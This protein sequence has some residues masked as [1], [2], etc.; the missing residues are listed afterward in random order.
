MMARGRHEGGNWCSFSQRLIAHRE[1]W[2]FLM[3]IQIYFA[4]LPLLHRSRTFRRWGLC[5]DDVG[6]SVG[7]LVVSVGRL[8]VSVGWLVVPVGWLVGT[9]AGRYPPHDDIYWNDKGF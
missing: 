3:C 8:V 7:W 9:L 2:C 5:G 6:E 1:L 4:P